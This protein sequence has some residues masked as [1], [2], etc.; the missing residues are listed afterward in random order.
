MFLDVL[1]TPVCGSDE[2]VGCKSNVFVFAQAG[3]FQFDILR[4]QFIR[5]VDLIHFMKWHETIH[6][7]RTGEFTSIN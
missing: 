5:F 6:D 1:I 3:V 4:D 2:F 7:Q